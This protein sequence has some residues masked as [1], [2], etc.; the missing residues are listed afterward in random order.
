MQHSTRLGG[1]RGAPTRVPFPLSS[2]P[3]SEPCTLEQG[4][5]RGQG[6]AGQAVEGRPLLALNYG[7]LLRLKLCGQDRAG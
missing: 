1:R 2:S 6:R 5:V 7:A 4:D 3:R